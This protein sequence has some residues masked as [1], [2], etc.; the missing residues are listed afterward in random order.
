[1]KERIQMSIRLDRALLNELDELAS[2]DHVDRSEMARR[3]LETGMTGHRMERALREYRRSNMS[4]W[5]AAEIAGVSLYQMLDRIHEDGIPYE[6]DPDVSRRLEA[7]DA[8]RT[9]VAETL[10]PH[11]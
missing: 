4:A 9:A 11:G 8:S 1:M 6:F 5:K 2:A 7:P 10:A 3:L